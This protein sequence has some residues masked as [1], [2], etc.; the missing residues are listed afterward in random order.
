MGLD[1]YFFSKNDPEN[2]IAYFRKHAD[3][4]GYISEL[5]AKETGRDP[6]EFNCE[7]FQITKEVLEDLEKF[8]YGRHDKHWHGF[9]WGESDDDKWDETKDVL[10]KLRRLILEGEEVYYTSWW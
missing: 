7:D 3:L 8:V 6:G 4:H 10:A 5:W 9:F 2:P 1:M